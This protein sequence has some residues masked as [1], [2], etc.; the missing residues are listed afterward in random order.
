MKKLLVL[1]IAAGTTVTAN[2]QKLQDKDVPSSV[3]IALKNK[4]PTATGVKWERENGGLEAEFK[5]HKTDYSVV[6]DNNGGILE[7]EMGIGVSALPGT[8]QTYLSTHYSGQKIKEAAKIVDAGSKITYEA[9]VKGR[10]VVF[11][12]NGN[13]VKELVETKD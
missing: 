7:T 10:D 4:F 5:V 13:F 6:F 8:A 9:E 1:L 3:K 2:A 12:S 11:D